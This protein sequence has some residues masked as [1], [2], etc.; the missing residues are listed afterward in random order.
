MGSNPTLSATHVHLQATPQADL[1]VDGVAVRI[2][3]KPI[4]TLRLVVS[5][6][7]GPVRVSVPLRIGDEVVRRFVT[8][9]RRWIRKQ[10]IRLAARP[11]PV[12]AL[13]D[14]KL[15]QLH[16]TYKAA[17]HAEIP[18]LLAHWQRVI[19]VATTGV[20]V[21][22]MKTRWGSCNTRT[23]RI[24]LNTEL[25]KKPPGCLEYVLVHELVHLLE[26]GHNSRFYGYLDQ[27]LPDW[28]DRRVQL[29]QSPGA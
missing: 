3:R 15:E 10:Q 26:R 7:D 21:R 25:A 27:F 28:R 20:R 12:P 4:R 2:L 19:G 18:L 9:K 6:P 17:L 8:D 23:R 14:A 5:T 29:N 13:T 16:R 11:Q 22:R 24:A 1:Y